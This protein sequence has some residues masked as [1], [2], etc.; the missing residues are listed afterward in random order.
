MCSTIHLVT[1]KRIV[2]L[3][4]S[5]IYAI[6]LINDLSDMERHEAVEQLK[7]AFAKILNDHEASSSAAGDNDFVDLLMEVGKK[8]NG[9]R[10]T[11]QRTP[12]RSFASAFACSI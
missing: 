4:L 11:L 8:L 6:Q 1:S 7:A 12:S 9:M 2:L 10:L 5:Q 3:F